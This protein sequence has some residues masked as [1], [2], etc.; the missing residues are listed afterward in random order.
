[1]ALEASPEAEALLVWHV[2]L[3]AQQLRPAACLHS[4]HMHMHMHMHM[5]EHRA[6]HMYSWR[7]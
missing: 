1:L 5:Q 3:T 6:A 2:H 4:M 7:C